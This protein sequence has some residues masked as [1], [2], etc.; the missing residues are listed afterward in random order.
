M[1]ESEDIIQMLLE[2]A[3]SFF[4]SRHTL[5][6]QKG[7]IGQP[8][9]LDRALWA[10]MAGLGWLG[11]SLPETLSGSGMGVVTAASLSELMGQTLFPQP[12]IAAALMPAAILG[13]ADTAAA[14][15]L[16][17]GL[18]SAEQFVC[19]AWQEQAGQIELPLPATR[20]DN[21]VLHGRKCFVSALEEDS[22]VLV[23]AES[24]GQL[25]ILAVDAQAPGLS[26]ARTA[27]A[28]GSY[29]DVVFE[30]VQPRDAEPL[31]TG[32]TAE[33]ALQQAIDIARIATSAQLAGIARACLQQTVD[34]V[35]ER[36]QFGRPIAS[37]QAVR[38][39][40]VDLRIEVELAAAS[41]RQAAAEFDNNPAGNPAAIYAAKAR[42]ADVA[43]E[44]GRAAVQ[45]HGAMGFTVECDIGLYLR[46]ALQ[47]AAWLGG[48]VAM[49]R[50]F[51]RHAGAN[52][53][54]ASAVQAE[55]AHV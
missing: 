32:S 49:R 17:H 2:S 35:G 10:E 42:C 50:S 9:G 13:A 43:R 47:Y 6:S 34:Y 38:H 5:D 27:T 40:C 1:T 7:E 54:A 8:L 28:Q 25:V 48:P 21:G 52:T 31:L 14:R 26:I 15:E 16:A 18:A 19:L 24:A 51:M 12:Y 22:V 55:A 29:C 39:R 37:F 3:G 11:L 4:G 23:S 44:V 45:L 36:V 33:T 46:A 20:F 53:T 41:W 30:G